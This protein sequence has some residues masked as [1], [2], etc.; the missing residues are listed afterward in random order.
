MVGCVRP[1]DYN[2]FALL[3]NSGQFWNL[4]RDATISGTMITFDIFGS[5]TNA[6]LEV[7]QSMS[8][9]IVLRVV[10]QNTSCL[11]WRC[12]QDT[13]SV[14]LESSYVS[15]I[16]QT[17]SAKESVALAYTDRCPDHVQLFFFERQGTTA[18]D[19]LRHE[20]CR[21][22]QVRQ[23][24]T[25][26][27]PIEMNL[28]ELPVLCDHHVTPA[29]V[30]QVLTNSEK[31]SHEY[32]HIRVTPGANT[33]EWISSATREAT[34][35]LTMRT[36]LPIQHVDKPPDSVVTQTFKFELLKILIGIARLSSRVAVRC[37]RDAGVWV[38][39]VILEHGTRVGTNT[40]AN[41]VATVDVF[42]GMPHPDV[43]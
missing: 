8:Y 6:R 19:V 12:T 3:E 39:L 23:N 13:L 28:D 9:V 4:F 29:S 1:D 36:R 11:H 5:P 42:I 26:Q 34:G 20:P 14:T 31:F 17:T 15:K 33:V 37:V 22:I 27:D 2:F 24:D 18:E 32:V 25:T 30:V 7:T 43:A 21:E 40:G 35:S 38:H 10:V 16:A 41:T